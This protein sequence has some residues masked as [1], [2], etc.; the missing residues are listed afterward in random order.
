MQRI[1]RTSSTQP[2]ARSALGFGV[3]MMLIGCQVGSEKPYEVSDDIQQA[4]DQL[5]RVEI[6][7]VGDRGIPEYISGNLGHGV[8]GRDLVGMD[9]EIDTALSK[10][11]PAFGLK[12][13]NLVASRIA[14]DSLGMTHVAYA[15]TQKGLPVVGAETILHIA[16]DGSI[17]SAN[18]TSQGTL[19]L[20]TTAKLSAADARTFAV[21]EVGHDAVA[22]DAELVY[23]KSSRDGNIYLSWRVDVRAQDGDTPIHDLVFVDAAE[24]LVRDLHPQIHSVKNRNV[25][26]AGGGDSLPGSLSIA[27]GGQQVGDAVIAAAYDNTGTTWDCFSQ[28]FGRD[29]FNGSGGELRST[30]HY[31]RNYNNAFWNGQQMVYGD[32][33]GQVL[34]P[35]A[36]SLD[37]T[38]HELG[39]GVTQ[40]TAN[41]VYQNEPGALNEAM[42]D[43]FGAVC[44][45]FADGGVNGD[46]WK[47]GED[48]YTPN[49]PGD[50]LRYMDNP[51]VDGQSYDFYPER[52]TGGQDNGG[53]HLNSG[54]ANL[55]FKL[56]VTG[57]AHPRNKTAVQVPA[58]GMD[59][60]GAIFYRALTVYMGSTT[61]FAAAREATVQAAQDL[62]G[63]SEVNAI[64]AAWAAVGVGEAPTDPTPEPT[65][66]PTPNPEPT[67]TPNPTPGVVVLENDVAA[68]GLAGEQA[69]EVFFE[70]SVPQGATNLRFAL[71]G[72]DGDAD[73]Y[74]RYGQ[75][76]TTSAWD[77]RPYLEG[78]NEEVAPTTTREGTY[79]IMVRGY[80]AYSAASLT[81]SFTAAGDAGDSD[82]P[83]AQLENGVQ[84]NDVTGALSSESI[85]YVDVPAGAT[86]LRFGIGNGTGD[87]DLYVRYGDIPTR[88]SYD[89]RPY[90]DG[91]NESVY[92]P[93]TP[94]AGRWYVMVNGYRPYSGL[95]VVAFY[96]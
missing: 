88:T 59:K 3:A 41:L 91:N 22:G 66:E 32:G 95:S 19:E 13:A 42:S 73:L 12:R 7:R 47:L 57:G 6:V 80:R 93:G 69:T 63:A 35:L 10:I 23:V 78:N 58:I 84:L 33:D 64:A 43:I 46:T 16:T 1:A 94:P 27:E 21:A 62:Y 30:V 85:Y 51:T 17:V 83:Y 20:P 77:F 26:D 45:A 39:H 44:E 96:D 25:Y 8:A 9:A 15:E 28:I 11:A 34:G 71:S 4:L 36:T 86:N 90:R 92:V 52:Y 24:R 65:P 50:A 48:I 72:G 61:N 79:Y 55:A 49:Q 70:L 56:A 76:P 82:E 53:V 31:G 29:S 75:V 74:V 67:P 89:F 81:A 40:F 38:A 14:H 87:A 60:A 5:P 54:I 2:F 18:S 37:V 68:T